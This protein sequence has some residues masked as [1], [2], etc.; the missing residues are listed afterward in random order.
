LS[1]NS[2]ADGG[3]ETLVPID[4]GNS[5]ATYLRDIKISHLLKKMV[6][7]G[8]IVTIVLDSC[9]SG[10][11]TRGK[12]INSAV[13]GLGIVDTTPRPTESLVASHEELVATRRS[14]A[15]RTQRN[16]NFG[17]G[18]L[19]EAKGYVL[20]AVCRE[21]ESAHDDIFE[22]IEANGALNYW[23]LRSLKDIGPG[24][25]YKLLHDRIIANV[26]G[27]F[28]NQTPML[29]GDGSR[30]VFGSDNVQAHYAVT[31]MNIENKESY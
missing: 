25:T 18:W 26:H 8:L 27:L 4:I 11:A 29:E 9:H 7:K 24:I 2:G 14:L 3:D 6:D 20:L 28:E 31:V 22:G 15:T 13:R 1:Q 17:S 10:G 19:P 21:S 12:N 16:V 5:E 23:M 30:V